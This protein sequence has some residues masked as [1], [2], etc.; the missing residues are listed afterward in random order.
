MKTYYP[1]VFTPDHTSGGYSVAFPDLPGCFT[2]GTSLANAV[3]MAEDVLGLWLYTGYRDGDT[4][5]PPS[6]L[7]AVAHQADEIVNLIGYDEAEYL[8][9]TDPNN[10]VPVTVKTPLW[11][12]NRADD[13]DIDYSE[14][15]TQS[16]KAALHVS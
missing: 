15:F 13:T 8:R 16:L 6:A 14:L 1:A 11:L 10:L 7:T 4:I 5:A 3:D 9:R 12:I 2:C